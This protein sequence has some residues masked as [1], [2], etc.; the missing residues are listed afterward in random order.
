MKDW[1][2][3]YP[4]KMF[5]CSGFWDREILDLLG[6]RER[7]G[8]F[9]PSRSKMLEDGFLWVFSR[10]YGPMSGRMRGILQKS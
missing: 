7:L 4:F 5:Y 1:K 3:L 2:A 8:L 6:A 10:F 9:Y